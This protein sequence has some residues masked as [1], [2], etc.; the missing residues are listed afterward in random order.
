MKVCK[1]RR[2]GLILMLTENERQRGNLTFFTQLTIL[3]DGQLMQ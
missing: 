2:V 3:N 1:S